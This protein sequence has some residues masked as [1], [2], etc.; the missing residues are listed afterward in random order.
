MNKRKGRRIMAALL[1]LLSLLGLGGCKKPAAAPP[2]EPISGGVT[3]RTDYNAPKTITSKDI[4]E[5]DASFLLETRW[6]SEQRDNSFHFTVKPDAQGVLTAS[7]EV[8][9]ISCPADGALLTAL[10]EIVDRYKLASWNGVYR[11]TAGLAPEYRPGGLNVRYASGE[12]LAF[13]TDND[14]FAEWAEAFY[15][16][17]ALWFAEKGDDSLY[18]K[19]DSQV[20]DFR[21]E[22]TEDER[23]F[24]YLGVDVSAELAVSG[25]AHLLC[26]DD[27]ESKAYVPFPADYYEQITAILAKYDLVRRYNFSWYDHAADNYGNHDA[28]YFGMGPGADGEPDAETLELILSAD[29]ESGEKIRIETRK[30]SELA[31]MSPLLAELD[32]YHASLFEAN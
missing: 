31:G 12:T 6:K 22:Y 28:G 3:N 4:A 14:P 23:Y 30:A 32:A 8:L 25:E 21:V 5:L 24:R 1:C 2:E 26:R 19:E 20:V 9:G 17:F 11:V 13:T 27:G 16:A 15:D 29:Y 18:P 10:Q 7:E